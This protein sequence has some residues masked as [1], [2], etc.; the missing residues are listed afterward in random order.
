MNTF[1]IYILA[2][3]LVLWEIEGTASFLFFEV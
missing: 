3:T 1:F 2:V